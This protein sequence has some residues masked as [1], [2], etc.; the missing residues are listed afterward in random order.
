MKKLSGE[1]GNA[2][3]NS[4]ILYS[5]DKKWESGYSLMNTGKKILL[6]SWSPGSFYPIMNDLLRHKM[7]DKRKATGLR[8]KYEYRTTSEGR[9]YLKEISG[10]FENKELREFFRALMA[11]NF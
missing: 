6:A 1:I 10:H 8:V 11:N 3:L 7:L 2:L 5:C 4:Y 9:K